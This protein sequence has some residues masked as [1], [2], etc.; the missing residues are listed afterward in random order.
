[1]PKIFLKH[2]SPE[3]DDGKPKTVTRHCDMPGCRDS[4]D[5]RAPKDRDLSDYYW[6]CQEHARE[7]N[8]AW[9][10][11]SGMSD[12]EVENHIMRSYYGDRPTWRYDVDGAAEDSLRRKAGQAYN[13][14]E[15]GPPKDRSKKKDLGQAQNT[16]EGEALAIMGL[17]VPITLD[18]IKARY[19][20]L[21][22][23][24]HPDLNKGSAESE[25]ILKTINM[26]YTIL[27][28]AYE[29]FNVLEE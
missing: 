5:Y 26:A 16:P 22:K 4:G 2:K 14:S 25:E 24:F 23:Q 8:Q 20:M 1:M 12:G 27:K 19:K 11:F 21:A 18:E 10:F 9:N 7:Y 15:S 13:Y 17:E 28:L 6:F 29:K 3:F